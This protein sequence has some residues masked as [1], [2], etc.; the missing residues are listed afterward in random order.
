V[1]GKT[2]GM[3]VNASLTKPLNQKGEK[4]C[5]QNLSPLNAILKKTFRFSL[6]AFS[7]K[8][9]SPLTFVLLPQK[10]LSAQKNL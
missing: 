9:L 6:S 4:S 8:N 7:S 2:S 10:N 1:E 3:T 5:P